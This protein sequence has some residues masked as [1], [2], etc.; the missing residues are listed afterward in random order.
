MRI[1]GRQAN[2]LVTFLLIGLL[3]GGLVG[4]LTRPETVEITIGPLSLEVRG[5]NIQRGDGGELTN[6]QVEHIAII[7]LIGGVI[8][9]GFGF[10]I[11]RGKINL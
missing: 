2:P 1:L 9:L 6:S 4:Y 3:V 7:A 8:G 5:K 10:A 11:Q